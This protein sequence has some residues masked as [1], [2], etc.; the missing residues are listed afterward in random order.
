MTQSESL[1]TTTRVQMSSAYISRFQ[2]TARDGAS[3]ARCGL[4][5]TPHGQVQTPA[6]M[7]VGTQATVKA[8]T[9]EQLKKCRVSMLLCNAY[10]L[11]L[12][13]GEETVRRAGGLHAFMGWDGPILTDSG[14]YQVLSLAELRR[15]TDE[16][17][18]F[19]SHI[20]GSLMM[21]TPE[22]ATE[23]QDALGADVIMAFDECA[24]YPC[25][26]EYAR[27][28]T[29][30]TVKW[31]RRCLAAHARD[32][33]ALYGIVQGS[34][35]RDLRESCARSLADMDFP[36]Y[37][38]G[39]LCVGEGNI[40]TNEVLSYLAPLLPEDRPRYLM[41]A[42]P[43]AE[44]LEAVEKGI[45]L[46]DC[47]LPTRNGRNGYAFTS[48]GVVRVRN[49]KNKDNFGP[50]DPACT[51]YTCRSF[52]RAYLNHLFNAGELAGLTLVSMHNV[53]FFQNLMDRIRKAIGEGTLQDFKHDFLAS[54]TQAGG[55]L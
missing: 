50:L 19:K 42:G 20:D 46:F 2:V 24:P 54:Q 30:R 12:R 28:A 29:E 26:H 47:V 55:S 44:I 3:A 11:A 49:S 17:A 48:K 13:P 35:Y 22:R 25:T 23:I 18:E 36:G 45:D 39:G 51:C 27:Q 38:I 52:T 21:L 1:T 43:P 41:G 34:V 31:A 15:I 16:G 32:D 5:G 10:H 14:G 6:F 8:M 53:F 7:P 33:Q 37:A 40:V 9:P 4:L